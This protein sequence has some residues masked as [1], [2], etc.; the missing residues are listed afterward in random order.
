V[1]REISAHITDIESLKIIVSNGLLTSPLGKNLQPDTWKF[2]HEHLVEF[3]L[4]CNVEYR[5]MSF[6]QPVTSG[7]NTRLTQC[8]E[9]DIKRREQAPKCKLFFAHNEVYE[10]RLEKRTRLVNLCWIDLKYFLL[11]YFKR[12]RFLR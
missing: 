5:A 1:D 11:L 6:Y 3:H 12:I 2:N 4:A 8:L 7:L 10:E 9:Q